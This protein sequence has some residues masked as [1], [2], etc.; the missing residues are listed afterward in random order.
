VFY[1]I[2]LK[3]VVK[4]QMIK[5][6]IIKRTGKPGKKIPGFIAI[7]FIIC[8]LTVSCREECGFVPG[9]QAVVEFYSVINGTGLHSPVD[10]LSVR[11]LGREDSLLY[12]GVNNIRTMLLPM[13]GDAA[14]SGFIIDFDR[15]TDTLWFSYDMAP[16]FLSPEC[17]FIINFDLLDIKH[18]MNVIDSVVIVTREITSFDETNIRIYN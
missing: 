9:V 13:N 14:E 4:L 7:F 17:G 15:G 1:V 5:S 16:L 6:E 11:G 8:L 3:P 12:A 2:G 18:T 10:S